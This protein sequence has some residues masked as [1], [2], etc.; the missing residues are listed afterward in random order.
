[1]PD[2]PK[3]WQVARLLIDHALEWGWDD[4]HGGFY[5]KGESFAGEAF[6]RKKVWW[7]AAEGLNALLLMHI[8]YADNT[9]R[10]WKAFL[11][12]WD[13]IEKHLLDPIHGGWYAETTREGKLMGDGGKAKPVEGELSHVARI[14]ERGQDARPPARPDRSQGTCFDPWI[15]REQEPLIAA[16]LSP[17][18]LHN[19]SAARLTLLKSHAQYKYSQSPALGGP[20]CDRLVWC[21]WCSA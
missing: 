5:D 12:Q 3:A 8:R 11:K 2:D 21:A 9:D 10:Y 14:D 17:Q 13:F 1:M 16:D 20:T 4:E 15:V 19:E 7:T 18:G 6:D